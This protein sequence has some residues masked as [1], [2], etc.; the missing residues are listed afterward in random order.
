MDR[1]IPIIHQEKLE[2]DLRKEEVE[3][4]ENLS[5]SI[6]E[7]MDLL[8]T[9]IGYKKICD[10]KIVTEVWYEGEVEKSLDYDKVEEIKNKI[11]ELGMEIDISEEKEEITTEYEDDD[12]NE[13]NAHLKTGI[14]KTN[15]YLDI[16]IAKNKT[17]RD[18]YVEALRSQDHFKMGESFGFPKTAISAFLDESKA[19][20]RENLPEQI[21][22]DDVYYFIT[23]RV[24]SK[25]HWQDEVNL[26][27][28]WQK[29]VKKN[30]PKIYEEYLKE[31]KEVVDF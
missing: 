11:K 7:K 23:F 5:I 12:V 18:E 24:L 3:T 8:L 10:V 28:K 29:A 31:A 30:S 21:K 27:R 22:N 20:R 1:E 13:D 19:I 25:D 26:V 16:S 9:K 2:K 14:N 17:A 6:F 15:K 4:I